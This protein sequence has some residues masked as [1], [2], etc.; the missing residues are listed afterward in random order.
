MAPRARLS[1]TS[2]AL[3]GLIPDVPPNFLGLLN[4]GLS[5][6]PRELAALTQWLEAFTPDEATRPGKFSVLS[7]RVTPRSSGKV[8]LYLRPVEF[9]IGEQFR[10]TSRSTNGLVHA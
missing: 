9:E 8:S 10:E 2:Y 6:R 4:L 3:L 5:E 1:T 7:V